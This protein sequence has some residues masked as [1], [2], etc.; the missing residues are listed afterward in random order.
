MTT[1]LDST[2]RQQ[3]H[4]TTG[5]L[6]GTCLISITSRPKGFDGMFK[7]GEEV[8]HMVLGFVNKMFANFGE[9]SCLGAVERDIPIKVASA[10]VSPEAINGEF[11]EEAVARAR[12]ALEIQMNQI[13]YPTV[14][15][16]TIA[17]GSRS[18]RWCIFK[19]FYALQAA[20]DKARLTQSWYSL[21]KND[22]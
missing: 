11:K 5:P 22:N 8:Q 12:D 17:A 6:P 9:D 4:W 15:I 18:K 2:Q 13:T 14:L 21:R 1:K 19:N 16:L 20:A 7:N 3:H 10:G